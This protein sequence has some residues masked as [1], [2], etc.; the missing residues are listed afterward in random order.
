MAERG[1]AVDISSIAS[2][3]GSLP[4]IGEI[5]EEIEERKQPRMSVKVAL[6]ITIGWIFFCSALFRLWED[7]T[8]GESCYFMFISLSTIGLGDISVARRE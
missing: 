1:E 3:I 4:S 6:G 7:W 8:Y 5:E 2:E